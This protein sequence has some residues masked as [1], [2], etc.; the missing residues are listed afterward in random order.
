MSYDNYNWDAIYIKL[1]NE[2]KV[3][4]RLSAAGYNVYYPLIK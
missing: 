1:R 4:E 2:K 3:A